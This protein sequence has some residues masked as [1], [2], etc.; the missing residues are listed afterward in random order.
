[1]DMCYFDFLILLS[2]SEKTSRNL[3][4]SI[5]INIKQLC[6]FSW[7]KAQMNWSSMALT[8]DILCRILSPHI[9]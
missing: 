7:F 6:N 1:M 9:A 2:V 8:F 5:K 3:E 4:R